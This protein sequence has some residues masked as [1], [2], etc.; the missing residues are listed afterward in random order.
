MNRYYRFDL[1]LKD[2]LYLRPYIEQVRAELEERRAW[3][4][5]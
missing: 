4:K 3:E 5:Q 2:V 1:F